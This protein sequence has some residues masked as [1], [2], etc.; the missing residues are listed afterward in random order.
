VVLNISLQAGNHGPFGPKRSDRD[1]A[2]TF[3]RYGGLHGEGES[4]V[5]VLG[6]GVLFSTEAFEPT[7]VSVWL[8][9]SAR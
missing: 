6:I 8:A 7:H 3:A 9:G 4:R 5:S 2:G 1:D